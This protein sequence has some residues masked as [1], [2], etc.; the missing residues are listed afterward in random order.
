M[1]LVGF[2]CIKCKA[3]GPALGYEEALTHFPFAHATA[4]GPAGGVVPAFLIRVLWEDAADPRRQGGTFS[5]S[6]SDGCMKQY[7]LQ[8]CKPYVLDPFRLWKAV[9]GNLW[10]WIMWE[11]SAPGWL[12][13][14][15][16]PGTSISCMKQ[17]GTDTLKPGFRWVGKGTP[18]AFIEMLWEGMWMSGKIDSIGTMPGGGVVIDDYKTQDCPAI[19]KGG[20]FYPPKKTPWPH[21]STQVNLYGYMH[22]D[23]EGLEFVPTLRIWRYIKG[24]KRADYAWTPVP[25][26]VVDR[27]ILVA[28]VKPD[29]DLFTTAYATWKEMMEKGDEAAADMVIAQMPLQGRPMFGGQ[30]CDLYCEMRKECDKSLLL[31]PAMASTDV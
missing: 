18:G 20:E 12:A 23:L 2:V 11:H 24:I 31:N 17:D 14:V 1:P 10:H 6:M 22:A 15:A 30:K 25:V 19:G 3:G 16:V 27:E 28:R 26:P 9:E 7:M 21:E 5:P 29:Y 4:E 8:R 13:E